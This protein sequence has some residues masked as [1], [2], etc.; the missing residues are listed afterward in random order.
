LF[1]VTFPAVRLRRLRQSPAI[2]EL[3]AETRIAPQDFIYPFFLVEGRNQRRSIS[4]MPGIYQQSVDNAL[5]EIDQALKLGVKGIM[6]FG[7]PEE[8]DPQ[9]TCSYESHGV[10]Q[11]AT[12]TIKETFGTDI[13]V[14]TDTCLCEYTSHGHCGIVMDGQVLNDPTIETLSKAAVSQAEAGADVVCPSDMMDGRVQTIR[15]ALDEA[16]YS[17]TAIMSYAVKYASAF[18]SPFREAAE[19][20]PS[21]GDRRGYQMDYR[22]AREALLEVEQD[23]LEGADMLMVKPAIGYLDILSQVRESVNVPVV[24]YNVSGEYSMVKAA[25]AQGW[26]D[27]EKIVLELLTGIK[28]AGADLIVT[29]HALDAAKWLSQ[30]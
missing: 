12:R 28:R 14:M 3:V 15:W 18:Y 2:R 5:I 7:I 19:S 21:F 16:G 22:N 23:L 27:E 6:L 11:Q 17:D 10:V 20:A 24:A 8:K 4:S 29:Y 13:V 25:A 26:I 30:S 1:F 9:G